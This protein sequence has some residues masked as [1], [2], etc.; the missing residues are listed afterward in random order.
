MSY[1]EFYQLQYQLMVIQEQQQY[2]NYLI[3]Q[4]QRQIRVFIQNS[5][6]TNEM[7]IDLSQTNS[8]VSFSRSK[9]RK[10]CVFFS[11]SKLKQIIDELERTSKKIDSNQCVICKRILSCQSALKMHYRTHTGERPF[12]C[13]IC[14]RAFSTKGNLKTH[15]NIHRFDDD[16]ETSIDRSCFI[17][18]TRN[19]SSNSHR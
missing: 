3:E 5:R 2:Q 14:S 1:D 19:S 11:R 17:I 10:F 18:S 9:S 4:I 16:D 12:Q 15:M 6:K 13:S 7:T 8:S